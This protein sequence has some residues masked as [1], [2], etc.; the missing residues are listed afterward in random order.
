MS[1]ATGAARPRPGSRRCPNCPTGMNRTRARRSSASGA[2]LRAR[3]PRAPGRA[4]G[5]S[6]SGSPGCS[7]ARTGSAMRS[8]TEALG[9]AS[10]TA[11]ARLRL[12]R[13]ASWTARGR[14]GENSWKTGARRPCLDE[15]GGG[16]PEAGRLLGQ[17]IGDG[18]EEASATSSV[19]TT[20]FFRRAKSGQGDLL[21]DRSVVH[22]R[23]ISLV[24]GP[25]RAS[26]QR[27]RANRTTW[28]GVQQDQEVEEQRQV[29]DVVEVVL[30]LL[31]RVL[32]G[33]AVA[34]TAPAPSP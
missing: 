4:D 12:W 10:T 21:D 20:H 15:D 33:R 34:G 11:S 5:G 32:D 1:R 16:G 3:R 26:A 18:H 6:S 31:E 13:M 7:H 23:P 2:A 29:L 28:I 19:S 14:N 27:P 30:E 9:R 24:G 17:H 22:R 25:D 8:S